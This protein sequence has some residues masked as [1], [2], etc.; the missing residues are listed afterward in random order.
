MGYPTV[1]SR[2]YNLTDYAVNHPASPYNAAYHDTEFNAVRIALLETQNNLNFITRSD[3]YLTNDIVSLDTVTNEVRSLLFGKYGAINVKGIW[4]ASTQYAFTDVVSFSG[5]TYLCVIGHTSSASFAADISLNRWAALGSLDAAIVTFQAQ[6]SAT[7]AAASALA[8]S[9]SAG[10]A[11]SSASSASGSSTSAGIS[12]TN[13]QTS[14][15]NAAASANTAVS[16][17]GASKWEINTYAEGAVVYS[18]IDFLAYRRITAGASST[19]PSVTPVE[20]AAL[21]TIRAS[22]TVNFGSTTP[23]H[24]AITT[25][26]NSQA[27]T[28]RLFVASVHGKVGDTTGDEMEFD[29]FSVSA[30][31]LTNGFITIFVSCLTGVALGQYVVNYD[32]R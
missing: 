7:E 26:A 21:N 5:G 13:A 30:R 1:Y 29:A 2:Q 8:A 20:W 32:F 23:R 25:F 10:N 17:A 6:Q 16:Y 11:A 9:T 4:S 14:A 19:D 15:N 22:A 28:T 31:C 18:P 27:L 24:S 12:A 3:G